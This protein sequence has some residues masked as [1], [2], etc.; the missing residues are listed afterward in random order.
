VIIRAE[1]E[2]RQEIDWKYTSP[3]CHIVWAKVVLL[4]AE[5]LENTEARRKSLA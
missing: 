4:A 5:D 3:R 2:T 1:G